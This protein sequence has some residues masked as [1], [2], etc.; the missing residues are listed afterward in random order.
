M[1]FIITQPLGHNYGGILQDYALQHYLGEKGYKSIIT[2][3]RR[4]R[5]ETNLI[6]RSLRVI[7]LVFEKIV[8]N[9]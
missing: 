8:R 3:I 1:I 2:D 9:M 6:K 5:F 4:Y 7:K